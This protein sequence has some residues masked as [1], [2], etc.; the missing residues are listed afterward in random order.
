[1][2]QFNANALPGFDYNLDARKFFTYENE[3]P[4]IYSSDLGGM[5][6]NTL[7]ATDMVPIGFKAGIAGNYTISA[8]ESSD[9]TNLVL[10]DLQTST[11]TD[12]LNKSYTF[13]HELG[14]NDNR[15]ILHFTPL[16]I[17]ENQPNPVKIYASQKV[18][19]VSVPANTHGN[20]IVF[21]LMGQEVAKARID[22]MVTKKSIGESGIYVVKAI[23]EGQVFT[24]KVIIQ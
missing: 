7:P 3:I 2:I 10:E 20:F 14:N 17:T 11:F 6:I 15:F 19:Y 22:N 18:V 1:V 24:Q 9:F 12:L 13:S 4:Q 21:N 23:I 5:S 8:T 16:A